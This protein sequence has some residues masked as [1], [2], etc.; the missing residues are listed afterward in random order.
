[1]SLSLRIHHHSYKYSQ[2]SHKSPDLRHTERTARILLFFLE[3]RLFGSYMQ[4][5]VVARLLASADLSPFLR[6]VSRQPSILSRH[7]TSAAQSQQPLTPPTS[8]TPMM[9]SACVVTK[10]L[11][12]FRDADQDLG[13][14]E[15]GQA[16]VPRSE[17]AWWL[18][19]TNK[20]TVCFGTFLRETCSDSVR[21]VWRFHIL[22]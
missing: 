21:E 17:V 4:V 3:A 11:V 14:A 16:V 5:K 12:P 6:Y 19:C 22:A 2:L 15:R 7:R 13:T 18:S 9:Q 8:S 20:M 10:P 1:M